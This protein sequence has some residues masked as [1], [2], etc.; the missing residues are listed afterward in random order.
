MARF[1][2]AAAKPRPKLR[3][4]A[5]AGLL[6]LL[7]AGEA[8]AQKVGLS[9]G[10]GPHYP[11]TPISIHVIS[12]GFEEEPVPVVEVPPPKDGILEFVTLKPSIRTSMTIVNGTVTRSKEVT[13]IFSYSFLARGPGRYRVGPFRVSQ[14]GVERSTRPALIVVNDAVRDDR[15]G[16]RVAWPDRPIYPGERIPVSIEWSFDKELEAR[17]TN[18]DIRVPIFDRPDLFRFIDERSRAGAGENALV[19]QTREGTLPLRA[20]ME[21]RVE[22][23]RKRRVLIAGRVLIPLKSGTFEFD[24]GVVT[25]DEVIRWRR[26]LFGRRSAEAVQKVRAAARPRRLVVKSLPVEGRPEAFAGAIG[27]GFSLEVSADRSVV[28]VGDPIEL[29]LVLRGDGNLEGASLPP[30]DAGGGLPRELFRVAQRDRGGRMADDGSKNF[31]V[32]VRVLDASVREIPPIA[33]S[34]FDPD[35]GEYRT[36]HSRPIALSVRRAEVVT[37]ADVVSGAESS[38]E[39]REAVAESAAGQGEGDAGGGPD[40][41]DARSASGRFTLSGANLSIVRDPARLLA[42][43]GAPGRGGA[44]LLVL[45]LL[46]L[47]LVPAA[48]VLRRRADRDPADVARSKLMRDARARITA[49]SGRPRV[50]AA[51]DIAD[52]LRS[53]LKASGAPCPGELDDFLAECDAIS[54]APAGAGEA[55]IA[56]EQ[57][58]RA[59]VL[60][61]ALMEEGS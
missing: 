49:A 34:Y 11:G 38:S 29:S 20:R 42:G 9:V 13:Y 1:H 5:I 33:Y 40:P 15:I 23:G 53:M 10:Q 4:M 22:G 19:L 60:A 27:R 16:L 41:S 26:D 12:E 35:V 37:A 28:Q 52:A 7:V 46:P 17:I 56:D 39:A 43:A 36:V 8:A 55:P 14:N 61:A 51:R 54:F 6:L 45:Y 58:Q 32:P 2:T 3:P 59:L 18:Y 57:Q 31:S 47:I 21:E 48:L 50:E 44:L 30:L 25:V 24:G